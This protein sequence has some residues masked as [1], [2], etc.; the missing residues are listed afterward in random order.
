MKPFIIGKLR[1][2]LQSQHHLH[3]ASLRHLLAEVGMSEHKR[4]HPLAQLFSHP[5][6]QLCRGRGED[7]LLPL[8]QLVD[9]CSRPLPAAA[10]VRAPSLQP[11]KLLLLRVK[12]V[13]LPE[14]QTQLSG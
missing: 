3:A 13:T 1:S 9:S 5:L 14:L 10:L 6:P 4:L 11:P 8:S 7:R 12:Q 2:L